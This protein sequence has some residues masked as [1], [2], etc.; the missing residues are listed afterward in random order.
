MIMVK[1]FRCVGLSEIYQLANDGVINGHVYEVNP[2][3]DY[4]P[5]LGPCKMFFDHFLIIGEKFGYSF[6]LEVEIPK[7]RIIGKGVMR[8][9][10]PIR[11]LF[12]SVIDQITS[13]T[14]EYYV[15]HYL[16]SEVKRIVQYDQSWT[17]NLKP[18]M[19]D[20]VLEKINHLRSLI[21]FEYRDKL[22]DEYWREK[23][24][25]S[26]QKYIVRE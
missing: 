6:S 24:S 9:H 10:K 4:K 23:N 12:G 15:S 21:P 26:N 5:S 20:E 11:G 2:D 19:R 3:S 16:L 18:E 14:T 25:W 8:W 17:T 13:K 1:L 7:S 22:E